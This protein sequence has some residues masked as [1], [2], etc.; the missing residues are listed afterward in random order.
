MGLL[1][2]Q[3][4]KDGAQIANPKPLRSQ[5]SEPLTRSPIDER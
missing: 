3:A 5:A 1:A 2:R 4:S